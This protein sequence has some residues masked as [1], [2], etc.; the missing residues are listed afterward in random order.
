MDWWTSDWHLKHKNI[1]EYSQRPFKDVNEMD[2]AIINNIND[3]VLP[4]DRLFNLG[5]AIFGKDIDLILSEYID[6]IVCKNLFLVLGNHDVKK[7]RSLARF[8]TILPAEYLYENGDTQIVLSHYSMQ[9][10]WHM[11]KGVGHLY[12][13]SHGKLT[14]LPNYKSFDVGVDAWNFKPLSLPQVIA[15]FARRCP[16]GKTLTSDHHK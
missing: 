16:S 5:D 6:R 8:F 15:E 10:W 14:P 2:S 1:I 4:D 13:H 3:L 11:H 9:S 12:G 7:I